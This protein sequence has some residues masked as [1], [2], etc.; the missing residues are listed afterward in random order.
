[1]LHR[2]FQSRPRCSDTAHILPVLFL[3]SCHVN[4]RRQDP[5]YST[6]QGN[7]FLLCSTQEVMV[8]GNIF[9]NLSM[10]ILFLPFICR[11][12]RRVSS[13]KS[14]KMHLKEMSKSFLFSHPP[15]AF[16]VLFIWTLLACCVCDPSS[17]LFSYLWPR[18]SIFSVTVL[19][20]SN[21]LAHQTCRKCGHFVLLSG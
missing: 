20:S 11:L 15:L 7:G 21:I 19:T 14:W 17:F 12:G 4:D 16:L 13:P 10:V 1:M 6:F 9:A 5:G 8:V 3:S 18:K 2:Y